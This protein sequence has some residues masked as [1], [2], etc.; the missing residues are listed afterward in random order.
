MPDAHERPATGIVT[1]LSFEGWLLI[2]VDLYEESALALVL[3]LFAAPRFR[4]PRIVEPI[5][6]ADTARVR[7]VNVP[8]SE[9]V[10]APPE[11]SQI[12]LA[13][14]RVTLVEIAFH[15]SVGDKYGARRAMRW[16]SDNCRSNFM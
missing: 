7:R 1:R 11:R 5:P 12:L 2:G 13:R 4:T 10:Y 3:P 6:N 15:R 16:G 8:K 9:I 14:E